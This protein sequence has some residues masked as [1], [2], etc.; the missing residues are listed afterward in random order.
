M[1]TTREQVQQEF[2]GIYDISFWDAYGKSRLY[3][4]R[5]ETENMGYID[6]NTKEIK[7]TRP[8]NYSGLK[9]IYDFIF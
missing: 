3:A 1:K 9:K 4:K 2:S 6:L 7:E 5:N 8:G